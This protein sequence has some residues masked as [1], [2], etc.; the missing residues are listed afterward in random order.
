MKNVSHPLCLN[1]HIVNA[2]DFSIITL[3]L[4]LIIGFLQSQ[5]GPV[6]MDLKSAFD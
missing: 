4:L 1:D 5:M 2:S 3:R 6:V